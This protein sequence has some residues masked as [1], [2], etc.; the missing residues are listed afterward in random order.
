MFFVCRVLREIM[1]AVNRKGEC[2]DVIKLPIMKQVK[3]IGGEVLP[4]IRE[5][6]E[7]FDMVSFE[8]MLKEIP[9]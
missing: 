5:I 4:I 8:K 7:A 6:L 3:T 2:S 1:D 9:E